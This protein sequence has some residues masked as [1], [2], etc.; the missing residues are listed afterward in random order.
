LLTEA[1]V[2]TATSHLANCLFLALDENDFL[3]AAGLLLELAFAYQLTLHAARARGTSQR[4]SRP[5]D[6]AFV[7]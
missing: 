2:R 1:H 4:L 3:H 5:D 6:V 7:C